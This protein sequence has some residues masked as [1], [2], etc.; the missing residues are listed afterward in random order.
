MNSME[1]DHSGESR[2]DRKTL[3]KI[4]IARKQLAL[5]EDDYRDILDRVCGVRSARDLTPDMLPALQR[6]FRRLGYQGYLLRRNEMPPLPYSDC[7]DRPGRPSGK[8]LRMLEA[9][10]RSINGFGDHDFRLAVRVWCERVA[11]ISDLRLLDDRTYNRVLAASRR[12]A[13]KRGV[14]RVEMKR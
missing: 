11:D 1:P 9:T 12:L 7:D 8:Q 10:L 5:D 6:E 2:L 13:A 14:R 4:H 3:A